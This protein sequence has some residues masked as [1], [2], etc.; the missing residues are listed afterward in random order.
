M[1]VKHQFGTATAFSIVV[2][3]MVGT[4]VFTSLGFQLAEFESVFTLMLLWILGGLCAFC[5]ATAYCELATAIPRSGGEYTFL[6][7]TFH[8]AV[9]FV[10]GWLSFTVGFSA[11]TALV[12][13]TFGAYLAAAIPSIDPKLAAIGLI[14][15]VTALHAYSH[16]SSGGFKPSLPSSKS[17]Y[18]LD[19]AVWHCSSLMHRKIFPFYHTIPIWI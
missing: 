6:R 19:F 17:S 16:R 13:I 7:E 10:A 14:L 1:Q 11:P 2:G 15:M 3:G 12:A 5:G 8:P 9:G 18:C 4:G